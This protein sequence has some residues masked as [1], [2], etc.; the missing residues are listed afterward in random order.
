MKSLALSVLS[1]A[2]LVLAATAGATERDGF[3]RLLNRTAPDAIF[4]TNSQVLAR[5]K[6][7]CM[8]RSAGPNFYL[9][10]GFMGHNSLTN[11]VYCTV[12][13]FDST[14]A[15]IGLSACFDYSVLGK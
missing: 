12:P 7:T 3:E 9:A 11:L 2:L 4:L 5:A 10:P 15:L 1:T 8:C 6:V 13:T 14:G